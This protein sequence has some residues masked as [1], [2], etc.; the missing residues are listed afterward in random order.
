MRVILKPTATLISR[1]QFIPHPIYD[2]PDDGSE[3]VKIGAFGAKGCYDAYGKDGRP[4]ILNQQRVLTEHH[5]SVLEHINYGLFIEG[6][7]RGLSL[8]LNRHRTFAISQRSTRYTNEDD[9]AIVLSP[10]YASLYEKYSPEVDLNWTPYKSSPLWSVKEVALYNNNAEAYLIMSYL[11]SQG[12]QLQSYAREV[13]ALIE[14]NPHN[15]TGVALRKWARGIARDLLP[16]GVETRGTWTNNVRGW[17]W[18]IES[19]S[20][21]HAEDEIRRLVYE[22]Y[23][24]LVAECSLYFED[25]VEAKIVRGIP[26]LVPTYAKV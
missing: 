9:A 7:T 8:E 2:I 6:I 17:R 4:N 16:N 23:K 26:V 18:V 14:L 25:F 1:P 5:G 21:E 10:Y 11:N 12:H 19:R 13:E 20:N 15:L 22:I 3:A 24:V